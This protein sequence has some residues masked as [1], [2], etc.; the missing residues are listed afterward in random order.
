MFNTAFILGHVYH[1]R[2]YLT[3]TWLSMTMYRHKLLDNENQHCI[4]LFHLI[5]HFQWIAINLYEQYVFR[6]YYILPPCHEYYVIGDVLCTLVNYE[7]F[8]SIVYSNGEKFACLMFW[9]FE[10]TRPVVCDTCDT[11]NWKMTLNRQRRINDCRHGTHMSLHTLTIIEKWIVGHWW[12]EYMW[13]M[14]M[15]IHGEHI[16]DVIKWKYLPR[17][18]PFVR[19]IHRSP[20]NSPHKGQWRG[21]LMF[22]LIW[23]WTNAHYDVTVLQSIKCDTNGFWEAPRCR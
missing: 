16:G 18:C 14:W 15:L 12:C 23:A 13:R 22:S 10:I 21:A 19:G 2:A 17:Y 5:L 20:V 1:S 7:Y 4:D 3:F 8:H 6:W 9:L 11:S